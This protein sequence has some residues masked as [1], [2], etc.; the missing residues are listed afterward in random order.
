MESPLL[1]TLKFCRDKRTVISVFSDITD[2]EKFSVGMV[3]FANNDWTC[4]DCIDADGKFY[5][6]CAVKTE[7]IYSVISGDRYT[8]TVA[9]AWNG[10]TSDLSGIKDGDGDPLGAALSY[11]SKKHLPADF[12]YAD[13]GSWDMTGYVADVGDRVITLIPADDNGEEDG[14]CFTDKSVLTRVEL[15]PEN[16]GRGGSSVIMFRNKKE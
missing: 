6:L 12:E 1:D 9:S 2:P 11:A 10:E 4:M 5:G 14:V 7:L 13:S 16:D 15:Y 8:L 3:R